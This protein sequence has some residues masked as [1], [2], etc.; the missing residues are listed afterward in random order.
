MVTY[1]D[2]LVRCGPPSEDATEVEA[3]VLT[4][5]ILLPSTRREDLILK[6]CGYKAIPSLR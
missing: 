4:V 1:P 2:M 6:R 3:P 5:E